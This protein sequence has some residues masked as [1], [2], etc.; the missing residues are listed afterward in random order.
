MKTLEERIAEAESNLKKMKARHLE[1]ESKRK[2]EEA[3][4]SRKDAARRIVLV[5]AVVLEKVEKGEIAEAQFRKWLD[6]SLTQT[7]DRTLFKL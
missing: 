1:A 2:R 6:G 4:Q 3:L 5:G 7:D